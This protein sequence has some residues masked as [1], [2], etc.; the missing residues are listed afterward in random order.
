MGWGSGKSVQVVSCF[1]H[2]Q[3]SKLFPGKIIPLLLSVL[4]G[5]VLRILSF[6]LLVGSLMVMAVA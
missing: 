3:L 2:K 5:Q 1:A 4:V 6:E